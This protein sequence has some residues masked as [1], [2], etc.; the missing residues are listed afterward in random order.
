MISLRLSFTQWVIVFFD[1]NHFISLIK[2]KK[3]SSSI[4]LM[5]DHG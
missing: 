1:R 5:R 2:K 3:R 4:F